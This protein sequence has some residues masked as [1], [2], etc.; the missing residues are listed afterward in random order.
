MD[1]TYGAVGVGDLLTASPTAGHAMRSS[2][3]APG[4]IM[5][6]ALE[7]LR[8]GTGLIRVLVMQR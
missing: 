7:P 5:G 3:H 2:D 8:E 6:K 1:A 4:T